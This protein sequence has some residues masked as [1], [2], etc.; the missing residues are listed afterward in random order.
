MAKDSGRTLDQSLEAYRL[1]D[2]A[3]T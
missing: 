2:I 3:D 1:N